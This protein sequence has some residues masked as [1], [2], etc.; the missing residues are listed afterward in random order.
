MEKRQLRI[1]G[2]KDYIAV[3]IINDKDVILS[4]PFYL[5]CKGMAKISY[6]DNGERFITNVFMADNDKDCL[7]CRDSTGFDFEMPFNELLDPAIVTFI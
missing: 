3:D 1:S 7:L 4:T 6:K 5:T 2:L